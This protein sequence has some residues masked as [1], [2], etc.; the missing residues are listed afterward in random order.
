MA[1]FCLESLQAIESEAE[2]GAAELCIA[3][4]V[5]Q[6][7]CKQLHGLTGQFVF[8]TRTGAQASG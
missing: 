2:L 3:A 4:A 7:L 1:I 6:H 5:I 8:F